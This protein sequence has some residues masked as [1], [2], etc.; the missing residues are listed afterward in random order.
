MDSSRLIQRATKSFPGATDYIYAIG[1]NP[2]GTIVAAGGQEGVV[3][4]YNGTSGALLKTL[5]PPDAQPK[6]PEKKAAAK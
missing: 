3:R 6:A 1:V 4:V 5:L 2:E